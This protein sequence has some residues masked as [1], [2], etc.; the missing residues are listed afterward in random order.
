MVKRVKWLIRQ[1]VESLGSLVLEG[2]LER[3]SAYNAW[4]LEMEG[5]GVREDVFTHVPENNSP[6]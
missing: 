2:R 1:I 3:G 6:Q 5:E 4:A